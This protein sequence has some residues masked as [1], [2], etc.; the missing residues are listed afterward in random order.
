[1]PG[2]VRRVLTWIISFDPRNNPWK[3]V[4]LF[5]PFLRQAKWGWERVGHLS[6]A[7]C[8]IHFRAQTPEAT[9]PILYT[10][11]SGAKCLPESISTQCHLHLEAG[12]S[13]SQG[14]SILL[15]HAHIYTTIWQRREHLWGGYKPWPKVSCE[16]A[17]A[18]GPINLIIWAMR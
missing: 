18:L 4:L 11:S 6:Q 16:S 2:M 12:P 13:I 14:W 5:S 1:M 15:R 17:R 9:L 10:P 3:L 8:V 7:I